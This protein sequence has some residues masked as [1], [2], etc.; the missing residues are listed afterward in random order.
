MKLD[1]DK[2][3]KKGAKEFYGI[4]KYGI[5]DGFFKVQIDR[6]VAVEY[7]LSHCG[8]SDDHPMNPNFYYFGDSEDCTNFVAQCWNAAGLSAAYD[9]YCDGRYTNTYS[10]INVDDFMDYVVLRQIARVEWSSTTIKPGDI[11]Q[12]CYELTDGSQV[13]QH[14]AI[15]TGYDSNG[16]LCYA[17]H[18][19]PRCNWP[20]S[21]IYPNKTNITEIRFLVPL[22]P[23]INWC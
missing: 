20:L 19:D 10:W 13:W 7:A 6:R 15:I 3:V 23:T 11:V 18:S 2:N 14:S 9:F 5:R 1:L 21:A 17:G 12:F 4:I 16:G 8:E 22:Y